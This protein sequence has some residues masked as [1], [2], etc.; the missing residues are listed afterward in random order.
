LI[1][2]TI[3]GILSFELSF[4]KAVEIIKLKI[5]CNQIEK[6]ELSHETI[7]SFFARFVYHLL[8]YKFYLY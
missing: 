8:L 1:S 6:P 2:Y 4:F 7:A 5:S 3:I